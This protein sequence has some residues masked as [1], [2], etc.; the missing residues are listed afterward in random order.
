MLFVLITMSTVS[1]KVY[2]ET[3]GCQM[4]EY[5]SSRMADLLGASHGMVRTFNPEEAD[6]LLMNTCSIRE[7][8]EEKVF[9]ALGRWRKLKE[10]RPEM[11]IGVG[12][13]VASQEGETI[14]KRAPYVD[15]VF[16][17]QT[18]HRLPK[19]FDERNKNKIAVMDISFPENEKFD[20][21][22]EPKVEGCKAYIS[23]MEGCSKYCSFCV[24][25]YTRG[26]EISRPFDDVIAEIAHLTSQGVRE[27]TLLGQNVNGYRGTFHN[28][29][30]CSFAEL[31]KHIA[32][33]DG[34]GRIRYTTSHPLEFSDELIQAYTEIPKLVS[35]VHLPVQSGSDSM[36]AAM[37]RN[38]TAAD[39]LARIH[40]LKAARPD[41][42][43]SSDFIIGFPNETDDDF[44]ATMNLIAEVDFDHSFSFI[45]S[46]RPGTPAAELPDSVSEETK[47]A[48]LVILKDH[49]KKNTLRKTRDM[50][51]TT[52]RVL[53]EKISDRQEGYVVGSAENLRLVFFPADAS[54]VGRFVD[55][56]IT[57][58]ANVNAVRAGAPIWVEDVI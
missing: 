32:D 54:L 1:K 52:Q 48:R 30:I 51:G 35:H 27:I 39:Y 56:V 42:L 21:L 14:R 17:P 15:M 20:F 41:I 49:I 23:I 3:Q 22:P 43:I 28:G 16:G 44:M 45:F 11:V 40:K 24:V 8:A 47:K 19:L 46:K 33:I 5:D 6:V 4:N 26:E 38:H 7:K 36:L 58:E 37:K 31:L 55:V 29:E 34:I 53:V 13:C 10:K 9:S 2:I 12:G 18:L 57:E 50:I 25:P